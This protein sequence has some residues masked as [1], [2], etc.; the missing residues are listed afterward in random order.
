MSDQG[1]THEE[2]MVAL[3]RKS[4]FSGK[5]RQIG[6]RLFETF[7]VTRYQS[8]KCQVHYDAYQR[9]KDGQR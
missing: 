8:R 4:G 3:V 6:P 7:E 2:T 5:D 9:W 1:W